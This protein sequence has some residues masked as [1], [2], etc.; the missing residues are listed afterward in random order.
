MYFSRISIKI[1]THPP[2]SVFMFDNRLFAIRYSYGLYNNGV[3]HMHMKMCLH[4]RWPQWIIKEASLCCLLY[5]WNVTQHKHREHLPRI[6]CVLLHQWCT[7]S[8]WSIDTHLHTASPITRALYSL[9][10]KTSRSFEAARLDVM[11]IISL[12][13]VTGISA[14]LL[15]RCLSNF[16]AIKKVWTIIS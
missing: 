4:V 9:R 5:K 13:N 2:H 16:W 1:K 3:F 10:G 14:V 11:I 8:T 6:S 15:P 12:W 7:G